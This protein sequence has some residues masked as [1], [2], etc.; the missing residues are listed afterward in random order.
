MSEP[1][2]RSYCSARPALTTVRGV[3]R[4]KTK[5]R[6]IRMTDPLWDAAL[7]TARDAGENF[8]D[9]V[10]EFT[11]WYVRRPGARMPTRPAAQ[12]RE[13]DEAERA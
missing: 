11:E 13:T 3:A 8:P 5:P 1:V 7:D 10:R 2:Y 9:K 12:P 4:Q 6:P